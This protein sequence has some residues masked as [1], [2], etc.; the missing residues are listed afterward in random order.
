MT[1]DQIRDAVKTHKP[2]SV[3]TLYKHINRLRIKPLSKTR[4]I[5]QR[6]PED[7][8]AKILKDLGFPVPKVAA[9]KAVRA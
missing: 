2:M 5:P 7:A 4:Q 8:A 3:P 9:R 6:Y 1:I